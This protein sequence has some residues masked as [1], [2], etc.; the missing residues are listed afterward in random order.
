VRKRTDRNHAEILRA[1]RDF[2]CSVVDTSALGEGFPDA[3]IGINGETGLV[4][5]KDG[6]KHASKR[7]LTPSQV[8]FIRSWKGGPYVIITSIDSAVEF[9]RL[10]QGHYY[11][12]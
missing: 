8:K 2:G 10:L 6:S 12:S 9:A 5:I 11:S 3:V 7:K 1:F 4:E